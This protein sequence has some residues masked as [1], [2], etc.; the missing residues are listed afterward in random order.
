MIWSLYVT[1][2]GIFTSHRL[3]GPRLIE[4]NIPAGCS[5]YEGEVDHRQKRLDVTSGEL[6]D[7]VPPAEDEWVVQSRALAETI[8][9]VESLERL[10]IRSMSDLLDDPNDQDARSNYDRR[11]ARISELRQRL[12]AGR[13]TIARAEQGRSRPDRP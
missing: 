8:A 6:V 13:E 3:S 2:S 10:Q 5:A 7:F 9:E 4:A 11:K 1:E 12:T